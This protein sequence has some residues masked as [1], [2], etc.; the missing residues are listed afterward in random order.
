[1]VVVK[2]ALL[3]FLG[4]QRGHRDHSILLVPA[5]P[6]ARVNLAPN[7]P[8]D[9][10]FHATPSVGVPGVLDKSSKRSSRNLPARGS[11]DFA[12]L[13]LTPY[14]STRVSY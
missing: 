11:K 7:L 5:W 2:I 9:G 4:G 13:L 6:E 10:S 12:R 8:L 3:R 1:M 14:S